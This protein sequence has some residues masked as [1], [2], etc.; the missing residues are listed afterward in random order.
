ML[1]PGEIADFDYIETCFGAGR[2]FLGFLNWVC[3]DASCP[4]T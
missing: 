1:S 4:K 3:I 2:I